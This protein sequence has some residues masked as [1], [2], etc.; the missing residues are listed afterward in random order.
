MSTNLVPM[1]SRFAAEFASSQGRIRPLHGV[2]GGPLSA[3]SWLDHSKFFAQMKV[4]GIRMHD[5]MWPGVV[6]DMNHVFPDFSRDPEDPA[7]YVFP[8]TD[9][10]VGA[11]VA[12]GAKI[13]YRLGFSAGKFGFGKGWPYP[14]MSPAVLRPEDYGRWAAIACGIIRHYN[15]GWADGFHHDLRQWEVWNEANAS[16]WWAD[17]PEAFGALYGCAAKAIKARWPNLEVGAFGWCTP[18]PSSIG[19]ESPVVDDFVERFL[20]HV[21]RHA[22]PIDFVTWHSYMGFPETV[23]HRSQGVRE[24]LKRVGL[25]HVRDILGEWSITSAMGLEWDYLFNPQGDI[26]LRSATFEARHGAPGAAGTA[27]VLSLL[28]DTETAEAHY[29]AADANP[30]GMFDMQGKPYKNFYA[31]KAMARM[32]DHPRRVKVRH[33]QTLSCDRCKC[34]QLI[35]VSAPPAGLTLLAGLGEVGTRAAVLVSNFDAAVREIKLELS[36]LDGAWVSQA[37]RLDARNDLA[38]D[39]ERQELTGNELRIDVPAATV[40]LLELSKAGV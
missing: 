19:G 14:G 4:P 27:C 25:G 40:L 13:M 21:V 1:T 34:D 38:A 33:V 2:N 12:T 30:F 16:I 22:L 31:L 39:G 23:L 36:G 28:Q 6:V 11:A 7:S 5:A 17:T 26:A 20:V 15:E 8:D 3:N 24:C 32:C 37:Y 29:Y 35:P 18:D 10:Y 9:K